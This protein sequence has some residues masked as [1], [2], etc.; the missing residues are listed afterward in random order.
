MA[1]PKQPLTEDQKDKRN[2][3]LLGGSIFILALAGGYAWYLYSSTPQQQVAPPKVVNQSDGV[4]NGGESEKKPIEVVK[5]DVIA[6]PET[7]N[8]GEVTVGQNSFNGTITVTSKDVISQ[9]KSIQLPFQQDFG[10]KI[11]TSSC[12]NVILQANESCPIGFIYDPIRANTVEAQISITSELTM[13][14]G[15]KR[16]LTSSV[17]ISGKSVEPPPPPPQVI[18]QQAPQVQEPQ[19]E[20]MT[21]EQLDFLAKRQRRGLLE[22]QIDPSGYAYMLDQKPIQDSW[23]SI[24]YGPNTS[25]MPV[26]MTRVVTMDKP[27]PAVI[28]LPI[29]TRNPSRAVATV[30]RDIYGGDGRLVVIERG[31]TMIGSV[32]SI[33]GSGEEKVGI[34]WERI[35]R[36]DGSAWAFQATSGDAMGRSGVLGFIDNRWTERFG[37]SVLASAL[38]AGVDI[39]A[40]AKTETTSSNN[41]T[42]VSQSR[43]AVAA[44]TFR[45][46][47]GGLI[48]D[49]SKE[50][51]ALPV[52][53]TVPV[54]TRITVFATSDLWLRPITPNDEMRTQYAGAAT[55][56]PEYAEA[57]KRQAAAQAAMNE[58]LADVERQQQEQQRASG[59]QTSGV[60]RPS[61]VGQIQPAG[62]VGQGTL[63]YR[64]N[65]QT[66]DVYQPQDQSAGQQ[67]TQQPNAPSFAGQQ[68][69]W[70][71]DTTAHQK[72][73]AEQNQNP[74]S[75]APAR[76]P[77][78]QNTTIYPPGT[79]LFP[80]G[81]V[82]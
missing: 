2:K 6:S 75:D 65:Y 70:A 9:I 20:V 72:R 68:A 41:S 79:A 54:G 25:T 8:M 23:S 39:L 43:G 29:D 52:I 36:P 67:Y 82:N 26:D 51:Q 11:N 50:M 40:N 16:S 47:V 31:S 64:N 56:T 30:E 24:G 35:I 12:L 32:G 46:N 37:Y 3:K 45:T 74:L 33:G 58:D 73:V 71:Q 22:S 34:S 10:I 7:I 13:S 4:Y 80:T 14:D 15:S 18:V 59:P 57:Q 5:G 17:N 49:F 28:K 69:G 66:N 19:G 53:R 76:A 1:N 61:P 77:A 81:R 60:P 21:T 78:V 27:I 48:K 38:V 44:E 62:Q 55:Q 42:N 63:N